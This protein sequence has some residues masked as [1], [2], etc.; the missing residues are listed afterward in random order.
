MTIDELKAA[1]ERKL[2]EAT[3]GSINDAPFGYDH[4]QSVAYLHG[5]ASALQWMLEMLPS[6][7]R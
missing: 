3:S 5:K 4:E 6:V 2:F 7:V 1:A